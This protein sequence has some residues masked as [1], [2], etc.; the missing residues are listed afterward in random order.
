[1]YKTKFVISLMILLIVGCGKMTDIMTT[2]RFEKTLK[3]YRNVLLLSDLE[4]AYYFGKPSETEKNPPDLEKFRQIKIVSYEVKRVKQT[5]SDS[6][7]KRTVHISYYR[8]DEMK[9]R[10]FRGDELWEYDK[11]KKI[12]YLKSGLPDFK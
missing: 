12:W 4:K 8:T 11:E 9:Q 7:V 10:T 2:D 3:A 5:E 1:M 6:Q